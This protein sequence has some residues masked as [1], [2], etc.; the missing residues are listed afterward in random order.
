MSTLYDWLKTSIAFVL[1][2]DEPNHEFTRYPINSVLAALNDAMCM[3][4]KYRPDLFTEW[5]V[6]KLTAGRHQDVRGCCTNVLDVVEQ[7]DEF[8]NIISTISGSRRTA[9][10][11]KIRWSKP[12]CVVPKDA[13]DGYVID[14]VTIDPNLNGRFEINPPVPPGTTVY[15]R[16]K[17]V[18]T[19]KAYSGDDL[20]KCFN[21]SC[22]IAVAAKH[23]VIAWMLFGDRFANASSREG[24]GQWHYQQA[25]AILGM[26][27]QAE[28]RIESALNT[29]DT[30]AVP[31][32]SLTSTAARMRGTS[33]V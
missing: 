29:G 3:I 5:R 26:Q 23:F 15:A 8:G 10:R 31:A 32:S 24:N 4:A 22:D 14:Y 30:A 28:N 25:F 6:V 1:N 13:P 16:V 18:T 17:C 7:T 19:P 20:D 33:V 2:D 9:T 21:G 27:M 11:A 12:S